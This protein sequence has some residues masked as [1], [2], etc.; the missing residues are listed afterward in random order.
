MVKYVPRWLLKKIQLLW[1]SFGDNNFSFEDATRVLKEDD[2]RVIAL[3]LSRL[4][5]RGWIETSKDP[6]DP[7]KTLYKIKDVEAVRGISRVEL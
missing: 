6:R 4:S 7:R 1:K 3:A 2:S 5:Q